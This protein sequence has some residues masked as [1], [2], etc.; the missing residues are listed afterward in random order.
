MEQHTMFMAWK[1]QHSKDYSQIHLV[2]IIKNFL[3]LKERYGHY[4][5]LTSKPLALPLCLYYL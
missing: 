2:C 3:S 1:T 5:W 4:P